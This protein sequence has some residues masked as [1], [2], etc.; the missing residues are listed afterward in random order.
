MQYS[1]MIAL[2]YRGEK[3]FYISISTIDT[4][5]DAQFIYDIYAN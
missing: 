3:Y 1:I 2:I 4:K 5:P